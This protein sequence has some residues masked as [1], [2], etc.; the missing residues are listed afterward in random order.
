M[1]E[2]CTRAEVAI[3]EGL[4][5]FA[6]EIY[7]ITDADELNAIWRHL[8]HIEKAALQLSDSAGDKAEQA[9]IARG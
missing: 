6:A 9:M 1:N 2:V 5:D 7:N 8:R 3:R 4:A